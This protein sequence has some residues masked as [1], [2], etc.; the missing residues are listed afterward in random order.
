MTGNV[1]PFEPHRITV[2]HCHA[3]PGILLVAMQ[4]DMLDDVVIVHIRVS[5]L[6]RRRRKNHELN[7]ERTVGR[8]G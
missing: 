3:V 4:I 6:W 2:A 5:V 7:G 8:L 1:A